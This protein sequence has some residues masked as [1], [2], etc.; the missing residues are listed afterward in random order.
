MTETLKSAERIIGAVELKDVRLVKGDFW[1][2]VGS[3]KEVGTVNIQI[4][5]E[6]KTSRDGVPNGFAVDFTGKVT[7]RPMDGK[8]EAQ[9]VIGIGVAFRLTYGLPANFKATDEELKAFADLNGTFNAWPYF[10][11]FVQTASARMGLPPIMIPVLRFSRK[12]IER[13]ETKV[14]PGGLPA[15]RH[16]GR[17][18]RA[19]TARRKV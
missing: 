4:D 15:K 10:R 1:S 17:K 2:A 5:G 9:P 14:T 12:P 3:P 8:P 18:G 6:A 19:G 13:A 11:E 7:V 16:T